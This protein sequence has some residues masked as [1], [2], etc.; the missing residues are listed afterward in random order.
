MATTQNNRISRIDICARV[1]YLKIVVV[2]GLEYMSN[3]KDLNKLS[4]EKRNELL[5]ENPSRNIGEGRGH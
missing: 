3:R 2:I 5:R 4:L 1:C